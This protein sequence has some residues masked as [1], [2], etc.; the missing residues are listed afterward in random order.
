VFGRVAMGI[1]AGGIDKGEDGV[2]NFY[3]FYIT[4]PFYIGEPILYQITG[5][6]VSVICEYLLVI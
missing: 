4:N 3:P 1:R 6:F 2:T 5:D